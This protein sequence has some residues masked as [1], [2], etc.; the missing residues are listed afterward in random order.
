MTSTTVR[1]YDVFR[2]ENRTNGRI[3][4]LGQIEAVDAE[5]AQY[6]ANGQFECRDT[7]SLYVR[8]A[9]NDA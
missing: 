9:T 4:H 2:A 1:L 8:E 6:E 3:D 5:Q 7:C